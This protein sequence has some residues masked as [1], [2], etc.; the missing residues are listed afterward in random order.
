M[1]LIGREDEQKTF[2]HC[3][4]SSESK[5][6]A[7]YGRRRIGKT[8]LIRKYFG[9]KIFFEV[10]GLY[11][12]EMKD[13]LLHFTKTLAKSGYYPA[14]V[15][16]PNNWFA[17]FDLLALHID[18]QKDNKKKVIFIDE[19]PWFDTPRSKFLTAF[20]SFWNSYCTKRNDLLVVICG[21]AASWMVNK[22]LKN[23]GGLHNR[24]SE[25][26]Q[27]K[28]FTLYET[29]K[30]LFEKNVKWS[31]YDIAQ[32]YFTTGGVPFYLDAVRKDE[33]VVQFVDRACFTPNGVLFNEF[34]ELYES[35]FYKSQQH[36]EI[37]KQLSATQ[38]GYTRDQLIEKTKMKSGG[39]FSKLI[40]EL[41]QSG[42]VQK[43]IPYT[44]NV[45][46]VLYKLVDNFSIFYFKFM[47]NGKNRMKDSWAK[48]IKGQSWVSWSGFAFERLCFAHI[49]QIKNALGLS[50][51]E[52][53]IF[54]WKAKDE[55]RGA[56][57]DML[58]ERSDR[59]INVCEIK[60]TSSE[61]RI[62]KNYAMA[63]RHK[64]DLFDQL[65]EN[66]KKNLFLTMITSFGTEENMYAKELV[67]AEVKLD[68]LFAK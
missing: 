25:K 2:K 10:A 3:L 42:F 20:E 68:D 4:H 53:E 1:E 50:G 17:A 58:I 21:S 6:V 61:F 18:A 63:L 33:S 30:F 66:K 15:A 23:K 32:L 62:D 7:V 5:L 39:T 37:V 27:L 67:R 35:L 8:F 22:I 16:A 48:Q 13:Q 43:V 64:M 55:E 56:Q 60:F 11:N 47:S 14:A 51:I 26:I 9:N 49:K 34:D 54:T 45:N 19:L 40:D 46:G 24:V 31:K 52:S 38:Q 36:Q 59:V 57:I 28:T 29:E 44:A 12:G 65:P 41:E